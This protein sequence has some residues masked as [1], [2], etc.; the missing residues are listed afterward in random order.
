VQ[1]TETIL[2]VDDDPLVRSVTRKS[3]EAKGYTVLQ[4]ATGSEA[5]DFCER[6]PARIDLVLSDVVIPGMNGAEL[7][8]RIKERDAGIRVLLMS[9]YAEHAV[10]EEAIR[11]HGAHFLAKPFTSDLLARKVREVLDERGTASGPEFPGAA[12]VR[13]L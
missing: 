1:G 10:F 7:G 4:A 6:G 9:G 5:L 2:V 8:R 12:R 13:P 11:E 3:L